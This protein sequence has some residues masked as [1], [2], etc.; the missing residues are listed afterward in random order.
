MVNAAAF[1]IAVR[2]ANAGDLPGARRQLATNGALLFAVLA[3]SVAGLALV[4]GDVVR[5]FVSSRMDGPVQPV[6]LWSLLAGGCICLRQYFLNQFFLLEGNTRPIAIISIA[7]AVVAV[8]LAAIAV[9]LG[10]PVG[11]AIA[12]AATSAIRAAGRWPGMGADRTG[13]R[14]NGKRGADDATGRRCRASGHKDRGG[15]ACLLRRACPS[16]CKGHDAL[17]EAAAPLLSYFRVPPSVPST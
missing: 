11:G 2:M 7:E 17:A 15:R 5:L 16:L 3:A 10:G 4:S 13:D 8:L 1:P 6:M 14:C 9:P 12:L